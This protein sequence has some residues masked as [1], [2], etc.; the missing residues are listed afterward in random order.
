MSDR[1][2]TFVVNEAEENID[3]ALEQAVPP[4]W[5]IIRWHT[6]DDSPWR[7]T[8]TIQAPIAIRVQHG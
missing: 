7:H 2:R 4:G 1:Y 6:L 8:I 3:D 5:M